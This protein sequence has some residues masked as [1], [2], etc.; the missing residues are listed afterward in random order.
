MVDM[1]KAHEIEMLD[2][3]IRTFGVNSYLGPWLADNRDAIVADI[4]SDLAVEPMLPGAARAEAVT[5][6]AAAR[7]EAARLRQEADEYAAR[8]KRVAHEDMARYKMDAKRALL[9]AAE[10]L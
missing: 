8:V 10:G 3:A 1:T 6:L 2:S 5:I 9:R 4:Q 7:A